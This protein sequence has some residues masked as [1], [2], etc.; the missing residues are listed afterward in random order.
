MRPRDARAACA[1]SAGSRRRFKRTQLFVSARVPP[2]R[3]GAA[4][5]SRLP[6]RRRRSSA[7]VFRERRC[8]MLTDSSPTTASPLSSFLRRALLRRLGREP[9]VWRPVRRGLGVHVRLRRDGQRPAARPDRGGG[10][11]IRP[12]R[13]IPGHVP[14][15]LQRRAGQPVSRPQR[16]LDEGLP[17]R[18]A[19]AA[20]AVQGAGLRRRIVVPSVQK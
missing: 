17:G 13:H 11:R 9:G 16:G 2:L 18:R 3:E 12:P 15:R 19:H 4:V 1:S 5:H 6:R 10:V 8:G 14:R 7:R 20:P